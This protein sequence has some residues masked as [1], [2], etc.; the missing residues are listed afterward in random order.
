VI[1][2]ARYTEPGEKPSQSTI[3]YGRGEYKRWAWI[4][5]RESILETSR[6]TP[7]GDTFVV[8]EGGCYSTNSYTVSSMLILDLAKEIRGI[9]EKRHWHR[10]QR[11]AI[12][13]PKPERSAG[14]RLFMATV[15]MRKG[16][17][18]QQKVGA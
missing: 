6:W 12:C 14:E 7:E 5:V 17:Y 15:K 1:Q 8:T 2:Y 9:L 16:H 4:S 13:P 18:A 3:F 10:S 11:T